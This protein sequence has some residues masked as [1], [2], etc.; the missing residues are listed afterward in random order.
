VSVETSMKGIMKKMGW[1]Q[2][3]EMPQEGKD[4]E[5]IA[6]LVEDAR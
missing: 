4:K 3:Q 1:I 2:V 6:T 5:I